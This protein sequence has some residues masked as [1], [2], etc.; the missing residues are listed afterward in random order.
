LVEL[1]IVTRARLRNERHAL[2]VRLQKSERALAK[3]RRALEKAQRGEL[4]ADPPIVA[5]EYA[6]A[7]IRLLASSKSA[8]KRRMTPQKE[9]FTV[10]WLHS[11]PAGEVLYDIGANVGAHSLVATRRPQG[12]MRVVAFEPGASTF[13]VLCSNIVLNDAAELITPLCVPL[14]DRTELGRFGYS[15]LTAGAALHAG[16]GDEIAR[17]VVYWQPVLMYALD[18]LVERFGLPRPEHLKLDVDGA[19][20]NVLHGAGDVLSDPRLRSMLVELN[21][22]G[23]ADVEEFLAGHGLYRAETYRE[24]DGTKR[25]SYARFE[26]S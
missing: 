1:P 24:G 4:D 6:D 23:E 26:R 13:A 15:D 21:A 9:P 11:L 3:T 25:P 17:E 16:G 22:G 7:D 18:D 14:G 8:S 19:E 12:P 10:E 2:E 5:L 20:L